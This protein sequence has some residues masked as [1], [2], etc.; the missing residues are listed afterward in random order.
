MNTTENLG[1]ANLDLIRKQ[2]T[3]APEAVFCQGKTSG[4]VAEII[5]T[6]SKGEDTIF[7]T[8]ATQRDYEETKKLVP[9]AKYYEEARIIAVVKKVLP[10]KEGV[11]AVITAGTADIPVAE[12]AAVTAELLGNPVNRIYDVGVAG[13]H[14]LFDRLEEIRKANVVIV[15]AGMEGALPSVLGGLVERPVVAVPTSVGYGAHFEGLTALLAMLNSCAP[16]IGVVNIDNG[17]GAACLASKMN[18]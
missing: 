4:Q 18:R 9:E 5:Q 13:I 3:G 16:G 2:R 14:R 10:K 12:E 8:R 15:V 11:V 17:Y 1:F 6:L 7:G